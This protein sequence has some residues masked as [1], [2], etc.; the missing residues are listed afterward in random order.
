MEGSANQTDK[1]ARDKGWRRDLALLALL[2]LLAGGI[3]AWV[4]GHTEAVARDGIIFI[5]YA[6]QFEK[7]PWPEVLRNNPQH[8]GYPL[9]V[10]AVSLP[11]RHWLGKIDW[12]TMQWSAQL[13]SG[14]AGLLLVIPM[15]F[16]GKELFDRGVGF[17]AALLF[18]CL[19]VSGRILSDGLSEALFLLFLSSGL[20]CGVRGLRLDSTWR[21]VLCGVCC[22]LAYLTRPEG[23]VL[24]VAVTLVLLLMRV[25]PA[26]RRPWRWTLAR[27]ACV[28]LSALAIGSP[29]LLS[30]GHFTNKP[31]NH[32]VQLAW[33]EE[34]A[35]RSLALSD[36][37]R[38][39]L[40]VSGQAKPSYC[41][42]LLPLAVWIDGDMSLA[43]R[44]TLGLWAVVMETA[45]GFHYL[46]LLPTL[47][48]IGLSWRRLRYRPEAWLVLILCLV[49]GLILWRLSVVATYVS[50]RHVLLLILCGLFPAIVGFRALGSVVA[51]WWRRSASAVSAGRWG[52]LGSAP[53]WS[54]LL[55]LMTASSGFPKI[56]QPLHAERAGHRAAGLWLARHARPTDVV[57]DGHFGWAS[58]YAGR[59]LS[60]SDR[61]Q[62][63]LATPHTCYIVKGTSREH[64]NPYGPTNAKADYTVAQIR[65][66]GGKKVYQWPEKNPA[67][68]GR[69]VIWQVQLPP[70][71]PGRNL[72]DRLRLSEGGR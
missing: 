11:V 2:L 68:K 6:L 18:Q 28:G 56:I 16:L 62:A 50:E 64:P 36:D 70:G 5:H 48:G 1:A 9:S 44:R 35:H 29:Y 55:L 8:P 67:G 38:C 59:I 39:R 21:F 40:G 46:A 15:F 26:W 22:G 25:V 14:L 7:E 65:A 37:G 24:G 13:A 19:P 33:R 23:V 47:L 41:R 20:L 34:S 52:L 27:L 51:G 32:V 4:I 58:F 17:W 31:S 61:S 63:A 69:V 66:A 45:K 53:F 71:W 30:T 42:A 49:H 72:D 10:L 43:R 3:R 12:Q 60:D 57:L 54:G